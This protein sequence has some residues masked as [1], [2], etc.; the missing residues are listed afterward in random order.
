MARQPLLKCYRDQVATYMRRKYGITE[1]QASDIS[2]ELCKEFYKPLTAVVEETKEDG[3]PVI[4]AVDLA[5]WF[6]A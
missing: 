3:I 6:D 4:R 5:T 2:L 1:Q